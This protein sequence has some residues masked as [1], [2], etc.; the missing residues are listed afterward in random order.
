MIQAIAD[1][2][3][4][5]QDFIVNHIWLAPLSTVLLPFIEALIPSLP[6]TLLVSFNLSIMGSSLGGILGTLLT[7]VLSTLGS[8]L[9]M[10]LIFIIIRLTLAPYFAKKVQENKYG[11]KF[12]HL[13]EGPDTVLVFLILSNPFLPSS[14]LNYAL[15]LTEI[16]V[17][18][19]ILLTLSSRL[20]IMIFLV[21]LGSLFNI[22]NNVLNIIW[23]FV[24]YFVL[25]GLYLLWR[26]YFYKKDV[27]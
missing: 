3:A 17:S 16:K 8:F 12:L 22:Q 6:L 25:F 4:M 18:R 14:I 9:G 26:K 19:Y 24:V 27:L 5:F 7:I 15:S 2:W 21:F 10:L 23:V 20:V 11:R 13:V 1:F